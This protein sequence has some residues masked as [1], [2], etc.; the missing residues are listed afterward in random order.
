MENILIATDF[1]KSANNA[2][3]YAALFGT[4]L[5]VKRLI[6][7]NTYEFFPT[8]VDIPESGAL[9]EERLQERS[10]ELLNELKL[11][12]MALT[13]EETTILT[14]SDAMDLSQGINK[15][16]A[17]HDV[18]MVVI[19]LS[20]KHLWEKILVGSSTK[21]IIRTC[22]LPLLIVPSDSI[23]IPVRKIVMGCDLEE[24]SDTVPAEKIRDLIEILSAELFVV[25]VDHHEEQHFDS[26]IIRQQYAFYD[27]FE[28]LTPSIQYVDHED[29]DRGILTHA[30]D[31]QAQIIVVVAK[32]H[33]FFERI[34][35]ESI[36]KKLASK[37]RLPLLI[38]H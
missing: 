33:S 23:Y 37:S 7:Y 28:D 25:H 26:N 4:Q 27:L 20:G 34:T 3:R 1:S 5:K 32:K 31:L 35:K 22:R 38:I 29:I 36:S 15:L 6:L 9:L 10:L 19:G 17:E 30:E 18:S 21:K 12:L 14:V 13:T 8:S 16:A 2:A 11:E 24:V